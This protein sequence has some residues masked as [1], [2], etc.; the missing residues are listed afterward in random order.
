M[1]N[2]IIKKET[3]RPEKVRIEERAAWI[4]F[5]FGTG[6]IIVFSLLF[7]GSLIEY[8]SLSDNIGTALIIPRLVLWVTK[9]V[10]KK[11]RLYGD[12]PV[13]LSGMI[14]DMNSELLKLGISLS[15]TWADEKSL[16]KTG[17]KKEELRKE[18]LGANSKSLREILRNNKVYTEI[19][20]KIKESK[21]PLSF[22]FLFLD[23]NSEFLRQREIEEDGKE[24]GRFREEVK[25]TE[26]ILK[27]I[28]DAISTLNISVE[29]EYRAYDSM[30][31]FSLICVDKR[32]FI[33]PYIYRKHG[34]TT[35]WIEIS[36]EE[37]K[38]EWLEYKKTFEE[39]WIESK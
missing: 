2:N 17:I 28:Q 29:F 16:R 23:S 35:P 30:P 25:C 24:T 4:M 10:S 20:K 21:T 31:T 13:R 18:I 26:K 15:E 3:T 19:I 33:G 9:Y 12:K 36:G 37:K 22:K 34:Y 39:L 1:Q 38:E 11:V 5:C 27:A 32:L 14:K 7:R 6:I 8:A